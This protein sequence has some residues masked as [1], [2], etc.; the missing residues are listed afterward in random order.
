MNPNGRNDGTC[1]EEDV[2]GAEQM[3]Y[4]IDPAKG[5]AV[6]GDACDGFELCTG[7]KKAS[8]RRSTVYWEISR[9]GMANNTYLPAVDD[10]QNYVKG[11]N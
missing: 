10:I 8:N 11:K 4:I 2:P 3:R 1:K 9:L 7:S 5:L 6:R